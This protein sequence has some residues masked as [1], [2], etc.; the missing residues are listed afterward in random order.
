VK[1]RLIGRVP[2]LRLIE[3]ATNGIAYEQEPGITTAVLIPSVINRPWVTISEAGTEKFFF[4]PAAP[5]EEP[6]ERR[7]AAVFNALGDGTRLRIVKR[8][9]QK[10]AGLTELAEELGLAK[11]TVHQHLVVL[12][13]ARIVQ[14]L[15]GAAKT[16]RLADDRP[17]LE[18]LLKSYLD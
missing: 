12:R 4:Y 10:P 13:G 1:Q 6:P 17:D 15:V 16:N 2:P 5:L 14:I 7:V 9:A 18:Q 11:S 3:E 8:L